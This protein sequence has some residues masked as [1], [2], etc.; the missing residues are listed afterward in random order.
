MVR[1][2]ILL[3]LSAA[4]V[5]VG[6][7]SSMDT[8][9]DVTTAVAAREL[10]QDKLDMPRSDNTEERENGGINRGFLRTMNTSPTK[11]N[12]NEFDSEERESKIQA[13]ILSSL[14]KLT[15][16]MGLP[17]TSKNLLFRS[18]IKAEKNPDFV[19]GYYNLKGHD[20]LEQQKMPHYKDMLD[21]NEIWQA[22]VRAGKI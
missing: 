18:W 21:Y 14:S 22:R 3:V 11:A 20:F 5:A 2:Y 7:G 1:I 16:K 15:A 13:G 8:I 4:L 6:K 12:E 17:K 10:L 19:R 9:S